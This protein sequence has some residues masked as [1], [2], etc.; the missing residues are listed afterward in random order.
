M[1][2]IVPHWKNLRD[3]APSMKKHFLLWLMDTKFYLYFLSKILPFV[4]FS[5]WYS[6]ITG[7]QYL[8]G[9]AL[10]KPGDIVLN[11]DKHK[12]VTLLIPGEFSHAAVCVAKGCDAEIAE[13][14]NKNFGLITFMDFCKEA[15]RAVILRCKDFDEEYKKKFIEKCLSFNGCQYDYHFDLGISTL[16]CSELIYQSDFEHRLQCKLDD[17]AGLGRPYISPTGLWKVYTDGRNADLIWD[18]DREVK[19][20][21]PILALA[22]ICIALV[23]LA[24]CPFIQY[25]KDMQAF[26]DTIINMPECKSGKAMLYS[27]GRPTCLNDN[28][29]KQLE[30][31]GVL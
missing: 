26:R 21:N 6:A 2:C 28:D 20:S 12:L 30:N 8:R 17:L 15:D 14:T 18:S 19:A 31:A 24:G 9:Y 16:Y 22:F 13:M 3:K 23:F 29:V 25:Q 10:L 27:A 1:S 11:T 5:F 4:R 7:S